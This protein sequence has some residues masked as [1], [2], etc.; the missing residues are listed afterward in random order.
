MK[1]VLL[2]LILC[3]PAI[4]GF[5]QDGSVQTDTLRKDALN[6]YMQANDYIKNEIPFVN[7]VRDVKAAD[8]YI[9]STTQ[10]TGSGGNEYTYY[11]SG[12]L[13]YSGMN[14]TIM[15]LSGPNNT[16]DEIRA[17]SVRTLKMGLMRYV[18][19]TPLAEY[20]NIGFTQKISQTV[21]TDKWNSWVFRTSANGSMNSQKSRTSQNFS[22]SFSANRVTKDWKI[23]IKANYNYGKTNYN[24]GSSIYV[25]ETDSKSTSTLIVK[26]LS[27]HWS[28][29]GSISAG[30]SS[31]SNQ[32]FYYSVLPGIEYDIFPYSE[33]TRR[34][35]RILYRIGYRFVNYA[36]T[37]IY[38]MIQEGR[39]TH[40]LAAAY[41]V[42]EKWGSVEVGAEYSNYFHDWSKNNLSVDARLNLRVAKGLSL[43][44]SGGA[45]LIHDQ[46][47]LVKGGA[48]P[49]EILLQRKELATQYS[50]NTSVGLSYTFGSIYNNVVN[51]RF[52]SN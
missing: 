27:D 6:V 42:L 40:S 48:S 22:G 5:S 3:L 16:Q 41:E 10:K 31:Y 50:Y 19:K 15:Y 28:M 34:Q 25:S 26:S 37:T 13:T 47:G 4:R 1:R 20:V 8:V 49:E 24:T 9:I 44:L 18:I 14:D 12:Q 33:S 38:D 39:G 21:S 45:S 36:D 7:F 30:S 52:G 35:L 51:P 43:S 29:G 2:L 23:N 46:L 11:I 32:K 17:M